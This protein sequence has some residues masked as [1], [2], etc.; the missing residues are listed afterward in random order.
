MA[1]VELGSG[2]L[3]LARARLEALLNTYVNKGCSP[4]R[5]GLGRH[6]QTE[7]GGEEE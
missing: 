2:R 1:L 5:R 4:E 6:S 3:D 7:E